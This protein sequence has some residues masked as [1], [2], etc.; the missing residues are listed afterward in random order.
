ML[1]AVSTKIEAMVKSNQKTPYTTAT[2]KKDIDA[3]DALM[4]DVDSNPSLVE[5]LKQLVDNVKAREKVSMNIT[6][7]DSK[8]ALKT[9]KEFES[10]YQGSKSAA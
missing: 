1:T 10:Q 4:K 5:P 6:N 8:A 9:I 2:L 3:I 7:G